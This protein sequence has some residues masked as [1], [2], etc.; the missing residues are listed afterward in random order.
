MPD[1][2]F[3]DFE[4][5]C[6]LDLKKSGA[7]RYSRDPS[8]IVTVIGW[9]FDN[10][11][12]QA[13]TVLTL[14]PR[15]LPPEVEKHIRDGGMVSGW[16]SRGFE[17]N[18]I[19]NYFGLPLPP[20]QVI[21]TMQA[22]L[23]AGL[24]AALG[25]A[26]MALGLA[27]VKDATAHRL[28]L[29]LARPRAIRPDGSCRWWH[30]EDA[31][32]LERL[33]LYCAQ[34]VASE[35]AIAKAI[36]K[37]PE[38][39]V[40]ISLL[41][42]RANEKGVRVDVPV[43]RR[44]IA[45]ADAS[46]KKLNAECNQITNGAVTSPGSQTARLLAWLGD[47]SPGD[48]TK[49]TVAKALARDDLPAHV[50]RVLEIRQLAAKSSIKKLQAVLSCID[51]DDAI[52]GM[53]AYYGAART[54][55]WAGRLFQPQ[56]LP[57]PSLEHPDLAIDAIADGADADWIEML[58]GPPL[59]VVSS[60]LR[61]I[62]IPRPDHAFVVFDLSQIEARM[63]A[64]L[65]GQQDTVAVFARGDDVYTFTARKLGLNSRQEGKVAVL[66]LGYGMGPNKFI[67]TAATY[68]LTYTVEQ[69]EKIVRDWREA[70]PHIVQFWWALDRG[71]KQVISDAEKAFNRRASL[72]INDYITLDVNPASNGSPLMTIRLPSGRR[73]YYR[74]IALEKNPGATNRLADKS[75][76]YSGTNQITRKWDRI[77]SYGGRIAENSCQA[78]ARCVV[79]EMALE[80]ER[81]RLGDVILS[82]HDELIVEVPLADAQARYEAIEKVMNTTP[83][84]A[85][86][87]PVKAEGHILMR[88]GKG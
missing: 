10:E 55:R 40:Q 3:I 28:M 29:Q 5:A 56:N 83:S 84:W 21:D 39:E 72:K 59:E 44:M 71:A 33:R 54:G 70:N 11:P 85:P 41:D 47:H 53:L 26:G 75:V 23:H 12:E 22:A 35:R 57:R 37:L 34:D 27:I 69:A 74:D 14:G 77:R 73:L 17:S 45:I 63:I 43:V 58:F 82:V 15:R 2:L 52:R 79:A 4:T 88:Y 16:N 6:A 64:W 24:P 60:C 31:E 49:D 1:T 19:R 78:C 8:L 48:L 36:P 67:D 46:T 80:I 25:D 76:T 66:G 38:R 42:A 30:E 65:A 7:S 13:E 51:D 87:L 32:K 20:T 68:K 50:R 62:L 18:I 61:G 86:G 81:K 9:A